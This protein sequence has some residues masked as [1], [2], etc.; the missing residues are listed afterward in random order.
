MQLFK[1]HANRRQLAILVVALAMCTATAA[2]APTSQFVSSIQVRAPKAAG[3]CLED[4]RE[5]V[6]ELLK[7]QF[8][9]FAGV[10]PDS[11][12]VMAFQ[13]ITVS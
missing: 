6:R 4:D 5:L 3:K 9:E 2:Q 12:Y 8:S 13:T 7:E 1:Q 10:V 11:V